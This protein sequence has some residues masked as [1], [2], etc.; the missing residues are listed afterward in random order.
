MT[1]RTAVTGFTVLILTDGETVVF[2]AVAA[3]LIAVRTAAAA[4][5]VAAAV[6]AQRR[7]FRD[8]DR[9]RVRFFGQQFY[10]RRDESDRVVIIQE[11]FRTGAIPADVAFFGSVCQGAQ[12]TLLSAFQR[13][14]EGRRFAAGDAM[15]NQFFNRTQVVDFTGDNESRRFTAFAGAACT[16]DT[17]YIAFRVLR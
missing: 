16:T 11:F 14:G 9:R 10:S 2:F 6:Y 3:A 15:L 13:L 1:V 7:F 8:L 5:S 4:V 12:S 17:V